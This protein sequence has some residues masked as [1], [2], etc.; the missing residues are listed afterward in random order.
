MVSREQ[1]ERGGLRAYELGRLRAAAV[2]GFYVVPL[3]I[4]CMWQ[5]GCGAECLC[6]GLAV[7]VTSLWLR[8][9][10][11]EGVEQATVALIAGS[12]PLWVGLAVDSLG[13]N[14]GG[15]CFSCAAAGLVAGVWVGR[16]TRAMSWSGWVLVTALAMVV[17]LLGTVCLETLATITVGV[18]LLVSGLSARA[19][20]LTTA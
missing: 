4:A 5:T 18:A 17:A 20:S 11:R 19:A 2:V 8:W 6:L 9:R 16:R 13:L 14:V 7:L 12:L 10:S 1:L 15:A 3:T